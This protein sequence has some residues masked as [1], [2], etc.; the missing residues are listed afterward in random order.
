MNLIENEKAVVQAMANLGLEVVTVQDVQTSQTGQ[1]MQGTP[2]ILGFVRDSRI[3]NLSVE[4]GRINGTVFDKLKEFENYLQNG[5]KNGVKGGDKA[6]KTVKSYFFDAKSVLNEI[7]EK[8]FGGADLNAIDLS[9]ITS[10]HVYDAE[11]FLFRE[12]GKAPSTLG[13]LVIG[14]NSFCTFLGMNRWKFQY[15]E[16]V[17]REYKA[18]VIS[19]DEVLMMLESIKEQAENSESLVERIRL[20]RQ[21]IALLLGWVQGL[22]SCEYGDA[23]FD[24]VNTLY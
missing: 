15:K 16:N 13:R 18:D 24:D 19:N 2:I 11:K 22:R 9:S 21:E 20:K 6:K 10:N 12:S 8:H 1:S 4:E 17:G 3:F 5:R 14:W 7:S 23:R